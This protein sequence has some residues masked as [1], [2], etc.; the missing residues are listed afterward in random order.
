MVGEMIILIISFLIYEKISLRRN[1][2][3]K[4]II[5]KDNVANDS[6]VEEQGIVEGLL[7]NDDVALGYNICKKY[8]NQLDTDTFVRNIYFHCRR[9][10]ILTFVGHNGCGKTTLF[11]AITSKLELTKGK[12]LL[13][14]K[15]QEEMSYRDKL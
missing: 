8:D 5:L 11:N 6:I 12:I 9:G 14:G 4:D 10:E 3:K 13:L 7:N 15:Q 1:N 2:K